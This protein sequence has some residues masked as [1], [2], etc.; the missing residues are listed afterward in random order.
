MLKNCII[1]EIPGRTA[2]VGDN[3]AEAILTIGTT[4][5]IINAKRYVP[6]VTLSVNNSI[7]FLEHLNQGFRRTIS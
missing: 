1:Y 5:Q 7:K 4:F 3:S 6:V 2:V